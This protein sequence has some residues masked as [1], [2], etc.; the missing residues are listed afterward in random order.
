LSKDGTIKPYGKNHDHVG[1]IMT[2]D[3]LTHMRWPVA[4]R[5][6]I[7]DL[8]HNHMF[9][10]FSTQ[11]GARKFLNRVGD[12]ADD[13]LALR[14][15]DMFGKGTDEYQNSKT[16]VAHMRQLVEEARNQAAPTALSGLA[17]NGRDILALGIKPGPQIG[18][19]LESLMQ[20]VIENPELNDREQLL[21]LAQGQTNGS[22]FT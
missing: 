10:A 22:A 5:K 6:R 11:K 4:R 12:H 17:V 8:I 9:A 14:H 13:L 21:A 15:A 19:I 2:N 18:Q 7:S 1:A 20:Q 16:P 3:R